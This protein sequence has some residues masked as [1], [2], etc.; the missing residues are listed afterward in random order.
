MTGRV[1]CFKVCNRD[2]ADSRQFSFAIWN[3]SGLTDVYHTSTLASSKRTAQPQGGSGR[4]SYE[5]HNDTTSAWAHGCVFRAS[6][7]AIRG[8]CAASRH[9]RHS[10]ACWGE[11]CCAGHAQ[12]AEAHGSQQ[13]NATYFGGPH[14]LVRCLFL[15]TFSLGGRTMAKAN[16]LAS[17]KAA[18][19]PKGGVDKS[20]KKAVHAAVK[21]ET[22]KKVRSALAA[23]T[24][25]C[26][27]HAFN[28]LFLLQV[29]VPAPASSSD[30]SSDEDDSSDDEPAPKVRK[31]ASV[32]GSAGC[33]TEARLTLCSASQVVAAPGKKQAAPAAAAESSDDSSDDDSSEV[34]HL[35]TAAC[36]LLLADSPWPAWSHPTLPGHAPDPWLVF[37]DLQDDSDDEPATNGH[38]NGAANGAAKVSRRR[39]L[40]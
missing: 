33:R 12:A 14:L 13:A 26:I 19:K 23:C 6:P 39:L 20:A 5:P 31:V 16:K 32:A 21:Q 38:A 2:L 3:W 34:R 17:P 25:S 36:C 24:Y 15:C 27:V 10:G 40:C 18:L 7:P 28:A 30:E 22:K 9:L 8:L 35:V 4:I 29:P 37:G 11:G 1:G